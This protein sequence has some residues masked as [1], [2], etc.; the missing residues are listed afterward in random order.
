MSDPLRLFLG[1]MI[2]VLSALGYGLLAARYTKASRNLAGDGFI[3]LALLTALFMAEHFFVPLRPPFNVAILIPGVICFAFFIRPRLLLDLLVITAMVWWAVQFSRT[4]VEAYDHDLYHIQ[5][6]LWNTLDRAIFGLANIQM[7]L[8]FDPSVFV[9]ASGLYI[10]SLG[11]WSLSFLGTALI[12]AMIAADLLLSIKSTERTVR[13]YAVIALAFLLLEP[14]WV[15]N[16]SYLSPDPVLAVGVVYIILLYLDKRTSALLMCVPFLITVKLA[17]APLLL[18]LNYN[19]SLKKYKIAAALGMLFLGIW[20]ARNVVLSGHLIFPVAATKL[21]VEWAEPEA[22]TVDAAEWITAWA[23]WPGKRP[24]ETTGI[25]WIP[26]W[27]SRTIVDDRVSAS[28]WMAA[29]GLL[30]LAWKKE[31]RRMDPGLMLA[32]ACSLAFW[33]FT[34]PDIRFGIGFLLATGFLLLAYGAESID[35]LRLDANN[36]WMAIALLGAAMG[37]SAPRHGNPEWPKTTMPA[38]LL[39]RTRTGQRIWKPAELGHDQCGS[40]IPCSPS[41]ERI[42]YFPPRVLLATPTLPLPPH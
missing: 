38:V 28:L 42:E 18:L 33:F 16:P 39:R 30:L 40:V 17:A 25:D 10:P 27:F 36:Q 7:R 41:P 26:P 6:A 34:A 12:E 20:V 2:A 31:L 19:R 37:L 23:R 11:G 4:G 5:A 35:L 1:L 22:W 15:L 8:G 14:G 24:E 9:L 21:P 32:L 29:A 3:G 13:F